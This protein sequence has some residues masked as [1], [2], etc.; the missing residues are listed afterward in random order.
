MICKSMDCSVARQ[1]TPVQPDILVAIARAGII[2]WREAACTANAY[3]QQTWPQHTLLPVLVL[4]GRIMMIMQ[5]CYTA[6][7]QRMRQPTCVVI[8]KLLG[9]HVHI[10][11]HN[12]FEEANATAHQKTGARG[13]AV[14]QIA[15]VVHDD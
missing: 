4:A 7:S 3:A 15:N 14:L 1:H 11:L 5:L 10:R 12:G 6:D 13:I 9:N 8:L 2:P